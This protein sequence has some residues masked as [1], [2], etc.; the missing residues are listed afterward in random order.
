V[1]LAL[2]SPAANAQQQDDSGG[3]LRFLKP[4]IEKRLFGH[5][6]SKPEAPPATPAAP[7]EPITPPAAIQP[8]A[9]DAPSNAATDPYGS[10]DVFSNDAA[11]PPAAG[12]LDLRG[13]DSP[14]AAGA[15]GQDAAPPAAPGSTAATP[16]FDSVPD[17]S[18]SAQPDELD[19]A[20]GVPVEAG[21]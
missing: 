10:A 16:P 11:A 4:W 9:A 1:A 17:D 5:E 20:P 12:D 19:E 13:P 15:P 7:G 6:T 18:L 8:D 14:A 2:A 21:P 3:A